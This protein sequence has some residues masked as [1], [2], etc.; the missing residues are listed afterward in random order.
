MN[1]QPEYTALPSKAPFT[2]GML[3]ASSWMVVIYFYPRLWAIGTGTAFCLTFGMLTAKSTFKV[4]SPWTALAPLVGA[5][6]IAFFY[7]LFLFL[8]V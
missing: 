4:R 7:A 5:C 6:W 8:D 1:D 3:L 2:M